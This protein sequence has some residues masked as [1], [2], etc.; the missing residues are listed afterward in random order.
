MELVWGF[1]FQYF[2]SLNRSRCCMKGICTG[3]FFSV[4][5]NLEFFFFLC[6]AIRAL[7]FLL[8]LIDFVFVL[9]FVAECF[10]QMKPSNSNRP[11]QYPLIKFLGL[12]TCMIF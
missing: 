5:S 2:P 1:D 4:F 11:V 3:S 8:D 12:S 10:L 6:F 9:S 7:V